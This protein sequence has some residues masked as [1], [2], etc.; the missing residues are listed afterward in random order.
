MSL[1]LWFGCYVLM[2]GLVSK[3]LEVK[4][5]SKRMQHC[6]LNCSFILVVHFCTKRVNA[7][8]LANELVT[9]EDRF[10]TQCAA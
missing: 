1:G 9:F 5:I 3:G 7:N 4:Q 8:V 10:G 6:C 2:F